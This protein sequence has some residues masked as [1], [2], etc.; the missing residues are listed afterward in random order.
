L[1]AGPTVEPVG[2]FVTGWVGAREPGGIGRLG[3]PAFNRGRNGLPVGSAWCWGW[4]GRLGRL[5]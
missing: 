4:L 2:N 3:A 1:R 5:R